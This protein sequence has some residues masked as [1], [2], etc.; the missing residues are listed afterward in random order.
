METTALRVG[1]IALDVL[2]DAD[3]REC[4]LVILPVTASSSR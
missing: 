3:A 2:L 1:T 4:T